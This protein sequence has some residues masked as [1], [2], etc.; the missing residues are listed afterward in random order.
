MAPNSL[1][2]LNAEWW[3]PLI[4][5]FLNNMLVGTKICNT[6]CEALLT[7]GQTVNFP[8]VNDLTVQDYVQGTDVT[9]IALTASNSLLTIDQSKIVPFIVDPRQE[10]QATSKYVTTMAQQAA[11]RLANVIDQKILGDCATLAFQQ[12]TAGAVNTSTMFALMT[13]NYAR[14]FNQN[15]TDRELFCVVD[16]NRLSL[17][18]QT[19]VS[20]GFM[21]ADKKL[22]DGFS[23]FQGMAGGFRI[24]TSNNLPAQILLTLTVQPTAGDVFSL[25]GAT[26]TYVASGTATLPGDISIGANLAAAQANTLLALN[27]TG[28]PGA[29]TYIDISTDSRTVYT[30]NLLTAGAFATNVSTI[31]GVGHFTPTSTF[32]NVNN[33]L[34]TETTQLLF[35]SMQAPSLAI[36]MLPELYIHDLQFQIARNYMTYTLFGSTVFSRDRKRLVSVT[37]NS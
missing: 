30:N 12:V 3:K 14:L 11:F 33:K 28:T 20:S 24:Y 35:G 4:Q 26:W 19:F 37:V 9:P 6:K 7:S 10:K 32:A 25:Y 15:A 8:Q 34:G 36:Q 17:L 13:D 27:G 18:A 31:T 23:P 29:T 1:T 16:S 2:N 22:E 5:D 21:Q